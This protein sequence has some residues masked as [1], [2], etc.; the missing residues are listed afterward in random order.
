MN[1]VLIVLLFTLV[2]CNKELNLDSLLFEKFQRFIKKYNKK[3]ESIN[4]FL[5]RFQV[6]KSNTM[7]A[8]S[9]NNSLYKTG[10]TNFQ[11]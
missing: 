9:E 7:S 11:I 4:E 10:I 1:K 6:F 2:Y 5:A 3:Y 8:L